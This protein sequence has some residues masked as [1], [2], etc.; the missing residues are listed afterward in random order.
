M[1][2]GNVPVVPWGM[3]VLS[4]GA[5]P[6]PGHGGCFMEIAS[7]LAGEPWSDHPSCTQPLL[8]CLAR[9]VNDLVDHAAR[10]EMTA[11]I[12]Q[13]VGATRQHPLVTASMV[14]V[15]S[16]YGRYWLPRDRGVRRAGKRAGR[17]AAAWHSGSRWRRAWLWCS[18]PVFRDRGWQIR[19][20]RKSVV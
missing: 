18:D 15:V 2:Q 8:A 20:D 9:S 17:R 11:W 6:G 16:R 19:P 14:A 12:P 4:R 13:V 7:V 1:E 10:W 3:P 5:H